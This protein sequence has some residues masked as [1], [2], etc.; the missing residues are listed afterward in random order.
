MGKLTEGVDTMLCWMLAIKVGPKAINTEFF[1]HRG[2]MKFDGIKCSLNTIANWKSASWLNFKFQLWNWIAG[3]W[4]TLQHD[5]FSCFHF[6]QTGYTHN[7]A[8]TC[9]EEQ[10][11][12]TDSKKNGLQQ[13]PQ[14][15]LTTRHTLWTNRWWCRNQYCILQIKHVLFFTCETA[16]SFKTSYNPLPQFFISWRSSCTI[17]HGTGKRPW[18][19]SSSETQ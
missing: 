1:S 6:P 15:T 5:I 13:F 11:Y 7:W 9:K 3:N 16:I 17:P 14:N 10:Q 18:P 8:L 2:N 12:K 4:H 19:A